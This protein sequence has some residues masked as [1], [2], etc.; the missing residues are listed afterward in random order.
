MQGKD[1]EA[2][3]HMTSNWRRIEMLSRYPT[4]CSLD[5]D[6]NWRKYSVRTDCLLLSAKWINSS[7]VPAIKI[8]FPNVE[9]WPWRRNSSDREMKM[10]Q[11][12]RKLAPDQNNPFHHSHWIFDLLQHCIFYKADLIKTLI[13]FLISRTHP[14]SHLLGFLTNTH[15]FAPEILELPQ[16]PKAQLSRKQFWVVYKFIST[17]SIHLYFAYIA[18][19]YLSF[20]H[21]E[22]RH[23]F[24]KSFIGSGGRL[25]FS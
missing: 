8:H 5:G 4:G 23:H 14:A 1:A 12:Q 10:T 18:N 16:V 3:G 11:D 13:K 24:S 25:G 20:Q 2:C 6:L 7:P 21:Y 22:I 15:I 19:Y 17:E 9:P